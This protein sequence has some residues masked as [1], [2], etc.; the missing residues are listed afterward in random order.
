MEIQLSKIC[1][2]C[3]GYKYIYDM[4]DD[5]KEKPCKECKGI[6]EVHTQS[7]IE[8]LEFLDKFKR[9]TS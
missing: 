4:D 5:Y 8:L 7:G 1:P 9:V 2:E 6:G 3:G